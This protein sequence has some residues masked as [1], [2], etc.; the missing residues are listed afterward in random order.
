VFRV[1]DK[2]M[3]IRNNYDRD[4]FNG[5]IGRVSAIDREEQVLIVTIDGRPVEYDVTDLDEL[6]HA[7]ACSIHKSQGSE[8]PAVVMPVMTTH[9]MML[10]RSIL[11]T[12][13]TRAK[14]L[15]VLVG[16]RKAIAIAVRNNKTAQRRSALSMRI[17]R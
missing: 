3:Q 11:Y 4:V 14:S 13:V 1:G 7:F 15:V 12:G 2:V 8:Y 9:Y 6:V 17:A 16:T 10:S 5:D